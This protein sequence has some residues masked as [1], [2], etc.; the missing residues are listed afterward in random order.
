MNT[1]AMLVTNAQKSAT[2]IAVNELTPE[3]TI[4]FIRKAAPITPAP[5]WQ[6]AATH[7]YMNASAV[8]DTVVA[9]WLAAAP[10]LDGVIL[11]T[12][13]N[14]DNPLEW[15][16]SNMASQGLMFVPDPGDLI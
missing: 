5:T 14:A 1:V 4:D 10:T 2:V 3:Y 13:T 6:T 11:F 9:A 8:P 15:A 7:W 12:A 16:Y